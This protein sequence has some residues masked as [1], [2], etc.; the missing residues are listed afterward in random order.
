MFQIFA[1]AKLEIIQSDLLL[2]FAG[3]VHG[4]STRKGGVS[5]GPFASLNLGIAEGDMLKRV[6]LN[7]RRFCNAL[8]FAPSDLVQAEQV[9]SN[10]TL[11]VTT[12]GINNGVDAMI[13]NRHGIFLSVKVADCAPILCYD[14]QR[15]VI[16]ALHAGWRGTV[17]GIIGN[18]IET[19]QQKFGSQPKDILAAVGPA[20]HVC[21][22]EVQAD[23]ASQFQ[24][25]EVEEREGRL[26]LDLP[27]AIA[28][29]LTAAGLLSE[30][31]DFCELCTACH[32]EFFYSYRRDKEITGRMMAV[33]GLNGNSSAE[34]KEK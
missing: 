22:Y 21:C 14:P 9:H 34:R 26:F 16:A 18:T 28:R 23:V 24:N 33:I 20:L 30:N 6:L 10:K 29:R 2:P 11:V 1:P 19:M 8:N 3:L 12:S 13:T 27:R 25:D 7:R 15:Q 5:V 17:S 31:L 32:P 4:F